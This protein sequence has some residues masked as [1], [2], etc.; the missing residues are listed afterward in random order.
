M[1]KLYKITIISFFVGFLTFLGFMTLLKEQ[2]TYSDLE[3][4]NLSVRPVFTFNSATEGKYSSNFESYFQDQFYKRIGLTKY[5]YNLQANMGKSSIKNVLIGKDGWL[6]LIPDS[7]TK[8]AQI[9]HTVTE[10]NNLYEYTEKN[11]IPLYLSLN[12]SKDIIMDDQFSYHPDFSKNQ[13]I[14][15]Q[16]LSQ[17]DKDIPIIDNAEYFKK[18]FTYKQLKDL[19]Y[20]TDHHWNYLGGYYGYKN[21]LRELHKEHSEIPNPLSQKKLV[22]VCEDRDST[23]F[24]GSQNRSLLKVFDESS[25]PVCS[26]DVE[27]R[28]VFS[29]VYQT[30]YTGD[31]RKGMDLLYHT[32][33]NKYEQSYAGLTNNDVPEIV[34]KTKNPPNDITALIIKDSYT[35]AMQPFIATHF[36]E[37]RILDM[38]HYK[39]GS[40]QDYIKEHHI[41]LVILSHNDSLLTGDTL[42]YSGNKIEENYK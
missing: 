12:P 13:D 4:R 5:Y 30:I 16:V 39:K 7:G 42:S 34:H 8:I 37:T 41:N 35:N 22:T 28:N 15:K 32:S 29:D 26:F 36:A 25:E 23:Y 20:K 11:N 6:A 38:R 10:I 9:P 2:R 18:T 14:K 24:L 19:Y 31:T 40:I 17:L 3:Y 1:K 33:L 21:L 27:D